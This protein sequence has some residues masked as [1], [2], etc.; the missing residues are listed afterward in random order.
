MTKRKEHHFIIMDDGFGCFENKQD[1]GRISEGELMEQ[2]VR[3][4]LDDTRKTFIH[5]REI[6]RL[7]RNAFWSHMSAYIWLISIGLL[8]GVLGYGNDVTRAIATSIFATTMLY[9]YMSMLV[10][11]FLEKYGR[12]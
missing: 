4:E 6:R 9:F 1:Y 3:A 5:G 2:K 11:W 12:K 7:R 10:E 8:V